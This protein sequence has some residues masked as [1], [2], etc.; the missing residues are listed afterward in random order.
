M[1]ATGVGDAPTFVQLPYPKPPSQHTQVHGHHGHHGH[2]G[3][4]PGYP[5]HGHPGHGHH[6]HNGTQEVRDSWHLRQTY[7]LRDLSH[8]FS[9]PLLVAQLALLAGL[10][11]AS[12]LIAIVSSG[13]S[14]FVASQAN[15]FANRTKFHPRAQFVGY[16]VVSLIFMVVSF[17]TLFIDGVGAARLRRSKTK[18]LFYLLTLHTFV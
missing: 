4:H 15:H 13:F 9:A 7:W 5:G 17:W 16:A 6:G 12:A 2:N 14:V 8:T 1:L 10:A 18:G 11:P 3:T